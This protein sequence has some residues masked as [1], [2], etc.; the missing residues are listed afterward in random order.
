M[1]GM[2]IATAPGRVLATVSVISFFSYAFLVG[3][4]TND[5]KVGRAATANL[6]G[7]LLLTSSSS[8]SSMITLCLP[9][10]H[11]CPPSPPPNWNLDPK[12]PTLTY[13]LDPD[14]P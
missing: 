3:L 11:S 1:A 13:I 9:P 5:I 8:S 2:D 7:L 10:L 6:R 12:P 14:P 4:V